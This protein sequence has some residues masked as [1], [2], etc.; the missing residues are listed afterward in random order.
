[1][2]QPAFQVD[3]LQ[4]EPGSGTTQTVG[5]NALTG[6][7]QFVSP[8][9]P[10]GIDLLSLAGLR[11]M[12]GVY[13]V[14]KS[15]SG[16][17][18]TTIQSAIDAVNGATSSA[19]NPAMILV[20]PGLYTELLTI[21][22]DGIWIVGLGGVT[23]TN[24]AATAHT[25]TVDNGAGTPPQQVVFQNIKVLNN[26]PNYACIRLAGGASSQIGSQGVWVKNC[27]LTN[28]V[29]GGYTIWA[30]A[31]NA[32]YVQGGTA[33]GSSPS[34][35]LRVDQCAEAIVDNVLALPTVRLDYSTGGTIPATTGSAYTLSNCPAVGPVTST[36]L[37]DGSLSVLRCTTGNLTLDGDQ[38]AAIQHCFVGDVSIGTTLAA[39][40]LASRRGAATGAGTLA[41]P[42]WRT[43][44]AFATTATAA[45]AFDVAGPDA[46]YSVAIEM[47]SAPTG[48]AYPVVE[49][50]T[51]SGFDIVFRDGAGLPVNQTVTVT[52]TV[53][54]S[55]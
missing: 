34:A 7:L 1:M 51:A 19:N 27:H 28:T 24:G 13:L 36:L 14:G 22:K 25:I 2:P 50:K 20:G 40:L 33:N 30:T 4:I 6:D 38:S 31:I 32:L 43:S 5:R 17:P 21:E 46:D 53:Q 10:A 26:A 11:N 52:V 16:A 45:V 44:A 48:G 18:Y 9:I 37:G 8:E 42:F 39:T 29:A 49:S 55:A 54:R 41:E 35:I 23:I 47:P 3:V 15:G 12:A